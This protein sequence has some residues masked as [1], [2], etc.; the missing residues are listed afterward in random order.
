MFVTI[1]NDCRD[2]NEQGRQ[3]TRASV[4]FPNSH[5][6]FIGINNFDEIEAAGNLVETIDAGTGK[7]GIIMVNAAPRHGSGKKWE[8]GTPFGYFFHNKKIIVSTVAGYT[9]SLAKKFGLI[10]SLYVTDIPKVIDHFIKKK[11]FDSTARDRTVLTQFRS[12]EYM[13]FLAK[14]LYERE[15]VPN[16]EIS[17]DDIPVS[18]KSI[19]WVDN[20]GNSKTTLLPDEVGFKAGNKLN[21][22]IG[23]LTCYNRLKDVP[24]GKAGLIIGSSGYQNKRFL[25]IVVQGE[26]AAKKFQLKSGIEILE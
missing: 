22:K 5:I 11:E 23:N 3:T 1:I 9:L 8:N 15:D 18:P 7:E 6:S 25:E 14:W 12:Y 19:W 2:P 13:P 17:I 24:N 20:F 4:L 26:S 10:E 16:E 21:L